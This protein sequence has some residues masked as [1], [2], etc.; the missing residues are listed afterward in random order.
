MQLL[1]EL[2]LVLSWQSQGF[3]G[4]KTQASESRP[5]LPV[6]SSE[7]ASYPGR[8]WQGTWRGRILDLG[9]SSQ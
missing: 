6:M 5:R 3:Q 7:A 2:L 8:H 4:Q 9:N 1:S